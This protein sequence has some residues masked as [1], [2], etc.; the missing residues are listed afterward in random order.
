M[1]NAMIIAILSL[2]LA[3]GVDVPTVNNVRAILTKTQAT[4]TPIANVPVTVAPVIENEPVYFGSTNPTVYNP[5]TQPAPVVESVAMKELKIL[6]VDEFPSAND[7]PFGA[8][9][10]RVAVVEDGKYEKF[11]EITMNAPDVSTT[12]EYVNGKITK[13][14]NTE[15]G[16]HEGNWHAGFSY[17]PT[18]AGEKIITFTSGDLT[19]TVKIFVK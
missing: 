15:T 8:F 1:T 10:L 13:K 7:S 16:N 19:K 2:L 3:F 12:P 11:T 9:T 17:I 5:P 18:S 14:A 6:N 4:T